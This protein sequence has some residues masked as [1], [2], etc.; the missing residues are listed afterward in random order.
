MERKKPG[1][2]AERLALEGDWKDVARKVANTK[3]PLKGDSSRV[4]K[5][6]APRKRQPKSG[7]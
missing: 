4:K 7:R 1:P 3:G 5:G 6:R 2:E